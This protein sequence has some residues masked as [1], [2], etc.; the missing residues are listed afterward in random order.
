MAHTGEACLWPN[1]T[2]TTSSAVLAPSA[3]HVGLL[4]PPP[5]VNNTRGCWSMFS[6]AATWLQGGLLTLTHAFFKHLGAT[7]DP[8][9]RGTCARLATPPYLRYL[10]QHTAVSYWPCWQSNMLLVYTWP[11]TCPTW[12]TSASCLWS[13][14]TPPPFLLRHGPPCRTLCA[15][16]PGRLQRTAPDSSQTC[17][18]G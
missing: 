13:A 14:P 11:R 10:P 12:S 3:L 17:L 9:Y 18:T 16:R 2:T 8:L 4:S 5:L 15:P 7:H 1:T 6:N